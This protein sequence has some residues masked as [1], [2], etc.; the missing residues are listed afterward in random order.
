MSWSQ[1]TGYIRSL[2]GGVFSN[3]SGTTGPHHKAVVT[4]GAMLA[5]TGLLPSP[6]LGFLTTATRHIVFS[7]T[8]KNSPIKVPLS[9]WVSD[10]HSAW[11]ETWDLNAD[12]K[13]L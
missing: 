8:E 5:G 4:G 12:G 3:V 1:D 13:L 9:R 6:H 10:Q 2:G 11:D 7:V